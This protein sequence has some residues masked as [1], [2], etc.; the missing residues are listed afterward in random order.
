MAAIKLVTISMHVEGI[1]GIVS[2]LVVH[3][4]MGGHDEELRTWVGEWV[5]VVGNLLSNY[6]RCFKSIC[7]TYFRR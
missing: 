5:Y 6:R 4:V 3:P 1:P 7:V 2:D